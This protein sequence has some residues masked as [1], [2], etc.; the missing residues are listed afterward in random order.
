MTPVAARVDRDVADLPGQVLVPAHQP[1]V[2]DG[3]RGDAG[4]E[5]Q[6][7]QVATG[8]A[9][10][11]G[12]PKGC[13]LDVV[14]DGHRQPEDRAQSRS[15]VEFADAEVHGGADDP[16]GGI[17]LAGDADPDGDLTPG[18]PALVEA[19]IHDGNRGGHHAV[20]S[21]QAGAHALGEAA[22][23][24]VQQDGVGLGAPDVDAEAQ[25][26]ARQLGHLA[27]SASNVIRQIAAPL[28]PP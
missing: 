4:A 25:P 13:G 9:E 3:S 2:D 20:R 23:G 14:V 18:R 16:G 17:H 12:R 15:E 10:V 1:S 11:I 19:V 24:G 5:V 8:K 7:G 28:P 22:A 21:G 27:P 6:V 26:G